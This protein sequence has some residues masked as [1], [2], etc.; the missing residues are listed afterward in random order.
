MFEECW[1]PRFLKSFCSLLSRIANLILQ[2]GPNMLHN[3]STAVWYGGVVSLVIL[4]WPTAVIP[5]WSLVW[6][7]FGICGRLYFIA[8]RLVPLMGSIWHCCDFW[9]DTACLWRRIIPWC[10]SE[11]QSSCLSLFSLQCTLWRK[12]CPR[13]ADGPDKW[14]RGNVCCG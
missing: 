7:S 9:D 12:P 2:R 5:L 13:Y 4:H 14:T 6:H 11:Q 3:G 1:G 10:I 8:A